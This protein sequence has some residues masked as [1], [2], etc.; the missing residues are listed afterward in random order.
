MIFSFSAHT[1]TAF[2]AL[3]ISAGLIWAL[4][5]Y[6]TYKNIMP[7]KYML[8]P[9][10]TACN[11]GLVILAITSAGAADSYRLLVLS[12]MI[13]SLIADVMLMLVVEK[14]TVYGM[15][16]FLAAH[17]LY[18]FAFASGYRAEVW[19][20]L[21]ALLIAAAVFLFN[22]HSEASGSMRCIILVYSIVLGSAGF[23]AVSGLSSG[24][25]PQAAFRAAG[26]LLFIFS[27]IC[28]GINNFVR[29]MRHSSVI[30]WATYA[31]AQLLFAL[32]CF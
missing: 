12:A 27:D 3:I 20:I 19:H 28:F 9:L 16:Y 11:L 13:C 29:P 30:T 23:F 21:P 18:V 14:M 10:I 32:S 5:E 6:C 8:T 22:R 2:R 7:L 25:Y 4:R 24:S 26:A 31:P 15:M 17:V 1:E